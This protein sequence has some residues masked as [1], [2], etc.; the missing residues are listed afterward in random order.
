MRSLWSVDFASSVGDR[1]PIAAFV[2]SLEVGRQ[3]KGRHPVHRSMYAWSKSVLPNFILSVL[4]DRMEMAHSVE[5]RVPFLD[6]HVVERAA[7][8]P[9]GML[10]RGTVEKYVLR[11]LARDVVT[12]KIHARQKHPFFAPPVTDGP[13]G[14]LMRDTL[15]SSAMDAVPFFD[16][17]KIAGLLD[18]LGS[19][20]PATRVAMDAP[21]LLLLSCAL[22]QRRFG[23]A[24]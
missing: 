11:E 17:K 8:L 2:G 15:R 16:R 3:L 23:L 7:R 14:E 24:A 22:L 21:L 19:L 1:D 13:L 4:G 9:V 20:P 6:H 18:G 5:G 12:D 10:I